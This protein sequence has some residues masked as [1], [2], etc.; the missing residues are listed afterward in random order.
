MKLYYTTTTGYDGEQ[1]NINRSLGG[2]KSSTP[3]LND[4]FD[5]L[6]GEISV[7]TIRNKKD[8]YR[9]MV[10][11]NDMSV[12]ARKIKISM[13]IPNDSISVFRVATGAMSVPD[14]YGFRK[15]ENITSPYSKPFNANFIDMGADSVL[16]VG[17]LA[18]GGEIGL[19][20]CRHIDTEKAKEQYNNVC[21][22]DINDPTGRRYVPVSLPKEESVDLI[23]SWV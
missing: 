10:L 5:N 14:K 2:Y 3:V 20:V 6:F 9:A 22:V 8:E 1:T 11:K 7:L 21:T 19:W 15:M 13:S 17:D 16:E 18:P 4:D 23:I 12:S